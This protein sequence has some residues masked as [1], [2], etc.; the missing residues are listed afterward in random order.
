MDSGAWITES[1]LTVVIGHF[2]SGKTEFAVNLAVALGREGHPF[3]LADL[4][5]VD[6]YFCA[7]TCGEALRS[8]GGRLVARSQRCFD[9]DAPSL[10][11][12]VMT[13]LDD[14]ELFGVLD[15]GGDASG[16]RVL[17]RYRDPLTRCGARVL[18]VVNGNRPL[19]QTAEAAAGYIRD[20]QQACG[21]AVTGL[22]NNTHLCGET[23]LEDILAGDRLCR[24]LSDLVG[25]PLTCTAVPEHLA[26][27]AAGLLP[28]VFPMKLYL[29][30]P[31]ELPLPEKEEI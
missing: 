18:C 27:Q 24:A 28:R 5:L 1:R 10:P 2:G 30:K 16:A 17:A 11:P 6:P 22:V 14:G 7:R 3:A 19:T 26:G 12:E 31:W 15:A 23:T 4:D 8:A 25:I 21:L 9:A 13:L 29:K 20:I